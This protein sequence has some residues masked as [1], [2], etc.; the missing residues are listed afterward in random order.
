[1]IRALAVV[2]LFVLQVST[3]VL[4]YR[5]RVLHRGWDAGDLIVLY[6]PWAGA[7]LLTAIAWSLLPPRSENIS[8]QAVVV[9]GI[10][11]TIA[12]LVTLLINVN[13]FGS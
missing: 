2:V 13:L 4:L 3:G 5:H 7:F 12:F 11:S 8:A 9:A 10:V 6:A 1:M